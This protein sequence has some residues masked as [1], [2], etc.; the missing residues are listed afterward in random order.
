MWHSKDPKYISLIQD[1][2]Q[3]IGYNLSNVLI[4]ENELIGYFPRCWPVVLL[5]ISHR[6]C[7]LFLKCKHNRPTRSYSFTWAF[8]VNLTRHHPP[9]GVLSSRSA[10]PY[11]TEII[12][13]SC[14]QWGFWS[15]CEITAHAVS[16]NWIKP[17]SI[18]FSRFCFTICGKYTHVI[19]L[20]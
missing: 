3:E 20:Q 6:I 19:L 16:Y 2:V 4:D 18:F 13:Y 5:K 15:C 7:T 9:P 12:S 8:N 11:K 1:S 10:T 14:W 17:Q